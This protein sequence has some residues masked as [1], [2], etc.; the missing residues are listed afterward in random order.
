MSILRSYNKQ[1]RPE[2]E[3][4]LVNIW[5]CVFLSIRSAIFDKSGNETSKCGERYCGSEFV[6]LGVH[7]SSNTEYWADYSSHHWNSNQLLHDQ[8]P[9]TF[10][11]LPSYL[12]PCTE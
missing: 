3:Y 9:E 6:I 2:S 5:N 4:C 7:A 12:C 1:L 10:G 11:V 8:R